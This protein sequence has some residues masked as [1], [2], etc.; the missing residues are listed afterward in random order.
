MK[1]EVTEYFCDDC[2]SKI[3]KKS[4]VR[5]VYINT[6]VVTSTDP[7]E[8]S[9]SSHGQVVDLCC[10]CMSDRVSHSVAIVPLDRRVYKDIKIGAS[11]PCREVHPLIHRGLVQGAKAK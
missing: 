2:G 1:K 3:S 8:R 11:N 6:P 9:L 4:G 7:E 5:S 10:A